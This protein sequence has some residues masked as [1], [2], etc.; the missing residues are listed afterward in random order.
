MSKHKAP[1][2]FDTM[3]LSKQAVKPNPRRIKKIIA[4]VEM[5]QSALP[6]RSSAEGPAAAEPFSIIPTGLSRTNRC[7]CPLKILAARVAQ[8]SCPPGRV[9]ACLTPGTSTKQACAA[10]GTTGPHWGNQPVKTAQKLVYA[11]SKK[12]CQASVR[13]LQTTAQ[14]TQNARTD[15]PRTHRHV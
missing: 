15:T 7:L 12:W 11:R 13:P 6:K 9:G 3:H 8:Y 14:Q 10:L 1:A 4:T 5:F 2:G